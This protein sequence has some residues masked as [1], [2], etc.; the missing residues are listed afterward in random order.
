M[1]KIGGITQSLGLHPNERTLFPANMVLPSE[2]I[3]RS[4]DWS[5]PRIIF[6]YQLNSNVCPYIDDN[7]SCLIYKKRPTICSSF[8][9]L[10]RPPYGAFIA[11]ADDCNFVKEI[12]SKLGLLDDVIITKKNF[13]GSIELKAAQQ[14]MKKLFDTFLRYPLDAKNYWRFDLTTKQWEIEFTKT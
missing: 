13:K 1:K 5:E 12:E 6:L 8:P 9:L 3:G 10:A 11:G 4:K 2:G 7:N 14:N